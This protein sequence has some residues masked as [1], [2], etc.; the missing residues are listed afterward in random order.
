MLYPRRNP[1]L[2]STEPTISNRADTATEIPPTKKPSRIAALDFT[3]GVLVLIM[4]LYHWMNYFTVAD[5]SMY[6]YLRFL[7]TSFI[8]ITGFLISHLYLSK[9][10]A[11]GLQVPR[12]LL[13]RGFKLLGIVFC[14]NMALTLALLKAFESR[15]SNWSSGDVVSAYLT[16][17]TSVAFSVLVPIAYLLILSA[18]LLVFSLH[19]RKVYHVIC[20]VV[21]T[22]VLLFELNGVQ[23]G[24]L[25]IFSMGML[26]ISCGYIPIERINTLIKHRVAI[27]LAYVA[28]L[29]AIT[30]WSDSYPLQIVGVCLSLVVIYWIGVEAADDNR[31]RKIAILLGRYSLFA[32]ITQILILQIL[33]WGVRSL[34]AGVGVSSAA[35]L[36]C[37]VCTILTVELLDQARIRMTGLNRLYT[38]VFC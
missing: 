31:S 35:F 38:A 23:S 6:K 36:A 13:I 34:G 7:P 4:V 25:Q 3:K 20:A 9:C 10:E 37:L 11:P 28:Y 8:F 29:V 22:C 15:V 33:R 21:V 27:C 1:L 17:R 26:G 14:L 12:R 24:Y 30:L 32:Y 18:G 2:R 5:G 19:Y 16:G